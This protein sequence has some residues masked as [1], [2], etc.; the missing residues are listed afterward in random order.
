MEKEKP[1]DEIA[2]SKEAKTKVFFNPT[3][4]TIIPA[5]MCITPQTT[6]NRVVLN[7]ENWNVV[8]PRSYM[9]AC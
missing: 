5:G 2:Q 6:A 1:N 4:F 9:M 8:K 7:N 3:L